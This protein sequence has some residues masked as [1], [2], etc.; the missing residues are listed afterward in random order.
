MKTM[1][2]LTITVLA[3]ISVMV[4]SCKKDKT[5]GD[6][7]NQ[8]TGTYEGTLT[9]GALKS[10]SSLATTDVS[11]SNDYTVQIHCYGTDLDTTFMLE[12]Y[13][14][15]N[16]MMVCV[17]G[18]DFYNEYGHDESENHHMMGDNG[19]YTS[20]EQHMSNDHESGDQHYGSF[21]MDSHTFDYTFKMHDNQ[22][23]Y[24]LHFSGIKQ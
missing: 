2:I 10:T 21:N 17:T 3:I 18:D 23:N 24:T 1:K 15:G 8:V 12:L 11:R 22:G 19:S 13:E 16:Q 9:L 4:I 5:A 7:T 20:W 14:N 6:L